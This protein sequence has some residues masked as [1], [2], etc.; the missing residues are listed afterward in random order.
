VPRRLIGSVNAAAFSVPMFTARPHGPSKG[1]IATLPRSIPLF[2]PLGSLNY[3][4]QVMLFLV[5]KN[6]S[7]CT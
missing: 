5:Y 4:V 1:T 2:G 6:F 7:S 3:T